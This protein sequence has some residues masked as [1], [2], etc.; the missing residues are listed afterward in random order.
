MNWELSYLHGGSLEIMLTVL[1]RAMDILVTVFHFDFWDLVI[2]NPEQVIRPEFYGNP[3]Y[4]NFYTSSSWYISM[5][6]ILFWGP[7]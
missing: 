4:F 2:E 5:Y 6:S 3:K 7:L 1:L